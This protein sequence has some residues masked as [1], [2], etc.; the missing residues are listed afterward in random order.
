[1]NNICG[2]TSVYDN[3]MNQISKNYC[4]VIL[5][6]S[7]STLCQV[8]HNLSVHTKVK[9][10]LAYVFPINITF[11]LTGSW[12]Y[13][14]HWGH[15]RCP[16]RSSWSLGC[17]GSSKW[18]EIFI[19]SLQWRLSSAIKST[20]YQLRQNIRNI[21]EHRFTYTC[22]AICDLVTQNLPERNDWLKYLPSHWLQLYGTHSYCSTSFIPTH[23]YIWCRTQ[24]SWK[25]KE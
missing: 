15:W 2:V 9:I 5:I 17:Y 10:S 7:F 4:Y 1:M 22:L 14:R 12:G 16:C 18:R 24:F 3:P 6:Y 21:A 19:A 25:L 13:W 11:L 23:C 20:R 8:Q